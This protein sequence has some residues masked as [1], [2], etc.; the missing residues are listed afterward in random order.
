MQVEHGNRLV[1]RLEER[2][3]TKLVLLGCKPEGQVLIAKLG[4]EER[5]K[6]IKSVLS[7]SLVEKDLVECW[8]V[9]W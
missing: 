3:G 5:T 9:G 7:T 1:N 2:L 6:V 8:S 4:L